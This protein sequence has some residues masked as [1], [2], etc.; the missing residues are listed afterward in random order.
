MSNNNVDRYTRMV[1]AGRITRA[2]AQRRR[3]QSRL[4]RAVPTL[5][6]PRPRIQNPITVNQQG[7]RIPPGYR[8]AEVWL[9]WGE[10]AD[11]EGQPERYTRSMCP[12][13]D[14][15]TVADLDHIL[16]EVMVEVLPGS[17]DPSLMHAAFAGGLWRSV[18]HP[19]ENPAD[20]PVIVMPVD[21]RR[22]AG[23]QDIVLTPDGPMVRWSFRP[24]S[25]DRV[26]SLD[27]ESPPLHLALY[28]NVT[29][30][31]PPQGDPLDVAR[32]FV[33]YRIGAVYWV[34][35]RQGLLY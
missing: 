21:I 34:K 20:P 1:Q 7:P 16:F 6:P 11:N 23:A 19:P 2:E 12:A 31:R 18:T 27:L 15:P 25:G 4:A 5:V 32:G 9:P 14:I 35:D 30:L 10:P 24:R 33:T 8:R 3:E 13:E 29:L 17:F 28:P 26:N 22:Y